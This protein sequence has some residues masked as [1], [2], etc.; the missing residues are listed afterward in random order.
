LL[1]AV[2]IE[3]FTKLSD[4]KQMALN[5]LQ[6]VLGMETGLTGVFVSALPSHGLL[7]VGKQKKAVKVIFEFSCI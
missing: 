1:V 6:K 4:G 2:E 7:Q 3:L 5:E